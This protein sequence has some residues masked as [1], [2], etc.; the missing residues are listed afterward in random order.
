MAAVRYAMYSDLAIHRRR[1]SL[2]E[3][4]NGRGGEGC[5]IVCE[6]GIRQSIALEELDELILCSLEV[7]GAQAPATQQ[8]A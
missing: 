3:P 4:G 1:V 5:S 6:D 7:G 2:G 8:E